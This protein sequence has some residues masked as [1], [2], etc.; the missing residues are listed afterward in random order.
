MANAL[1][2][3]QDLRAY[4]QPKTIYVHVHILAN[5]ETRK[6]RDLPFA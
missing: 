4:V 5:K 2:L 3:L 1:L 6:C